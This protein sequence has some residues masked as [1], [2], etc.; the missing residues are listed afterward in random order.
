M[1][2]DDRSREAVRIRLNRKNA[3]AGVYEWL[4]SQQLLPGREDSARARLFSYP[5]DWKRLVRERRKTPGCS[6]A[7]RGYQWRRMRES[8]VAAACE[9]AKP[10]LEW[11][12]EE[13]EAKLRRGESQQQ[14]NGRQRG[15]RNACRP[16]AQRTAV[17]PVLL[18][19]PGKK[20]KGPFTKPSASRW[21]YLP[22]HV[23]PCQRA[24]TLRW[25]PQ[26]M[27]SRSKAKV[28]SQPA[29]VVIAWRQ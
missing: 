7:R 17:A 6:L 16:E 26:L 18:L 27:L 15:R 8:V 5:A 3:R 28:V 12:C 4:R 9:E 21:R 10:G 1:V 19:V 20:T 13:E 11:R 25:L 29:G 22:Q 2:K 23:P 24:C 14:I